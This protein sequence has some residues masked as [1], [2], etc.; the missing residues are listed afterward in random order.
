MNSC[1]TTHHDSSSESSALCWHG[2]NPPTS[3]AFCIR[4]APECCCT[5][6]IVAKV[7]VRT[8]Q[9]YY[10]PVSHLLTSTASRTEAMH[11]CSVD[12]DCV[13]LSSIDDVVR[14]TGRDYA[15]W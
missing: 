15:L 11:A 3:C 14:R 9:I 4:R 1:G 2:L 12:T 7:L 10:Q 13:R 6:H 8:K 5:L